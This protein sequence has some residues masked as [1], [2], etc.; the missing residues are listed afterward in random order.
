MNNVFLELFLF[1]IQHIFIWLSNLYIYI[2]I[3]IYIYLSI[4]LSTSSAVNGYIFFFHYKGY[5][6]ITTTPGICKQTSWG[7][8]VDL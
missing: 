4:Y 8:C 6:A 5:T 3:Y 7:V 2:Y 1:F